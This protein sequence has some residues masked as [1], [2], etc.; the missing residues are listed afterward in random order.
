M[1]KYFIGKNDVKYVERTI[2]LIKDS[3]MELLNRH[4]LQSIL[5]L[6]TGNVNYQSLLSH[7]APGDEFQRAIIDIIPEFV[8]C[9]RSAIIPE[10]LGAI[11]NN[12][13]AS[14]KYLFT[15]M[16]NRK[17]SAE[18][19]D[20]VRRSFEKIGFDIK[21]NL[22][23][24]IPAL[25]GQSYTLI[26]QILKAMQA[27]P[28]KQLKPHHFDQLI[29]LAGERGVVDLMA[30]INL[31]C[32]EYKIRPH[33]E[34]I[35]SII[36]PLLRRTM[37]YR[38]A[39]SKLRR[40]DIR[41]VDSIVASISGALSE[42]DMLTAHDI[43]KNSLV[44]LAI[45]CIVQPLQKAFQNTK[46][47]H[48][49]VQMVRLI[50]ERITAE[51]LYHVN[52]RRIEYTESDVVK[53]QDEFLGKIIRSTMLAQR[54]NSADNSM[55]LKKFLQHGLRITERQSKYICRALQIQQSSEMG[56]LLS[57]LTMTTAF[58]VRPVS[59]STIAQYIREKNLDAIESILANSNAKIS[60]AE[61]ALL[62]EYH[63]R[64]KQ[65]GRALSVFDNAIGRNKQ[66]KLDFT[67]VLHIIRLMI[68][69]SCIDAI[70]IETLLEHICPP[71]VCEDRHPILEAVLNDLADE[72]NVELVNKITSVCIAAKYIRPSNSLLGPTISVELKRNNFI[73]AV[74]AYERFANAYKTTPST[75]ALLKALINNNNM[76]DLIERT[77]KIYSE[78]HSEKAATIRLA[79][80]Y[81]ECGH[82]EKANG[83]FRSECITN[84]AV[85][86]GNNCGTL[87]RY[88]KM[89][90]LESLLYSTKGLSC[91]RNDIY[92][93]LLNI[94]CKNNLVD[95]ALA[96][97]Q[98][99]NEDKEV[100]QDSVFVKKMQDILCA[101]NGKDW[102]IY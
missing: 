45:D 44:Y 97:H 92:N 5:K 18:E 16:S 86:I 98:Y 69:Q 22:D 43:A 49:F 94:Y 37:T 76:D 35:S 57:E 63:S 9:N 4:V 82:Y 80:A 8:E 25:R 71:T 56:K 13:A 72:R 90:A 65:L 10:I 87:A 33:R 62:I 3:N 39:L 48:R 54:S 96:L 83:L 79:L 6:A 46:D 95:K 75:I 100:K 14:A 27:N 15:E 61:Y 52:G 101:N 78:M 28:T 60:H 31:M 50:T 11:E 32:T 53:A 23:A 36:M 77:F 55:L 51:N 34:Y 2:E 102:T 66:F 93:R 89:I 30:A 29:N 21:R 68:E 17:C 59:T 91:D 70:K 85:V 42:D 73:G 88:D 12:K 41:L 26:V 64:E 19:F 74:D 40:T 84:L 7:L 1:L 20:M 47:V 24:Y 99:A 38:G 67:K 58:L 81:S